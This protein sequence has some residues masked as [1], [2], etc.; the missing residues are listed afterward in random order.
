MVVINSV[1]GSAFDFAVDGENFR[2]NAGGSLVIEGGKVI[3]S[4][5]GIIFQRDGLEDVELAR[6]IY[7]TNKQSD[8][9]V[10]ENPK[11]FY[12]VKWKFEDDSIIVE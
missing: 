3:D 12:G 7:E 1:D 11:V 8:L 10:G 6:R 4:T 9:L 5:K 2:L